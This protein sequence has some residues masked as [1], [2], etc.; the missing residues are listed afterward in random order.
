MA[1]TRRGLI[2]GVPD[3]S[4]RNNR[5]VRSVRVYGGRRGAWD[6]VRSRT[7]RRQGSRISDQPFEPT[8]AAL[9]DARTTAGPPQTFI[10]LVAHELRTPLG[11]VTAAIDTLVA[12]GNRLA[13]EDS[14]RLLGSIQRG[15]RLAT[16]LLDHL[17]L[18]AAA[19]VDDV[20]LQPAELET[21]ELV[22]VVRTVVSDLGMV[23]LSRH[24]ATVHSDGPVTVVAD[25][26][27]V[28]E[29]VVN[30][31]SN[32]VKYSEAGS[33]IDIYVARTGIL[34]TVTVEDEGVGVSDEDA[35]RIF[36]PYTQLDRGY[37]G[38]G[39]GLFISRGIARAHDGDLYV[40]DT[41]ERGSAF[42][43]ELPVGGPESATVRAGEVDR[44]AVA[45]LRLA[46]P[47][48]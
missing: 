38:V 10:D 44:P 32:A 48:G 11:V 5:V 16:V 1:G 21:I 26:T 41:L 37:A 23:V 39:L 22:D 33:T 46:P 31:L 8:L 15:A 14:A 45:P 29:V 20:R 34:A 17:V 24:R 6:P 9:P 12:S 18:A 47:P 28:R 35:E 3:S 4:D 30:L 40:G 36:D 19:H 43:L 27:G 42:V 13:P 2:V 7:C 25:A